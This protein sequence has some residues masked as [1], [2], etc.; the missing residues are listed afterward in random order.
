ML[1]QV[2]VAPCPLSEDRDSLQIVH[3]SI[4]EHLEEGED[5]NLRIPTSPVRNFIP[6]SK[7][8][9][10]HIDYQNQFHI[11]SRKIRGTT[12]GK[13]VTKKG[14]GQKCKRKSRP[15]KRSNKCVKRKKN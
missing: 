14:T 13:T 12:R 11:Q 6:I 15:T 10:S 5:C 4:F 3:A 7:Q 8:K 1:W 9:D 2:P